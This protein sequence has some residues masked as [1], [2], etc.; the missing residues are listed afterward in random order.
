MNRITLLGRVGHQGELKKSVNDKSYIVLSVATNEHYV[1]REG[2]HQEQTSWHSLHIWDQLAESLAQTELVGKK[3]WVEGS[4]RYFPSQ[5]GDHKVSYIKT[6]K[7]QFIENRSIPF[8]SS[9]SSK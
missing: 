1:D 7:L 2:V 6:H 9:G 5:M 3:I 8:Q 4:L